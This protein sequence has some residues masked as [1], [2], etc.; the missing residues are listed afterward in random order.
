MSGDARAAV[1]A[2]PGDLFT[3]RSCGT[4]CRSSWAIPLEG[5]E[6]GRI[7]TLF[8]GVDFVDEVEAAP[9]A[10]VKVLRRR[11]DRACVFLEQ[12]EQ[13]RIHALHGAAAKPSVCRRYPYFPRRVGG[14]VRLH[15]SR[16]CPT[17]RASL[18]AAPAGPDLEEAIREAPPAR[19]IPAAPV[20]LAGRGRIPWEAYLEIERSVV[21]LIEDERWRLPEGLVA[22]GLLL[23]RALEADRPPA[24]PDADETLDLVMEGIARRRPLGALYRY[25]VGT[26]VAA[27]EGPSPLRRTALLLRIFAGLGTV[28][29][30]TLEARVP[31][32]TTLRVQ[33]PRRNRDFERPLRRLLAS[34]LRHGF[35]AASGE[36][37]IGFRLLA[38]S[39]GL[40]RW[41]A[42]A[43][44]AAHGRDVV[45]PDDLGAG[46]SAVEYHFLLHRPWRRDALDHRLV[47]GYVRNF[48]FH[49]SF[50]DSMAFA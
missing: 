4:C 6:I 11:P 16:C 39:Y 50:V 5:D 33:W 1:V 27:A 29:L 24:A 42:R 32:R 12:N 38:A 19:D 36:V 3:C 34:H 9:G 15:L 7:A 20:R 49:P 2:P 48:L 37:E 28:R 25:V 10:R 30:P 41:Y 17:V 13:C 22:A 18:G 47:R 46:I 44:A 43:A 8:P 26:A 21:G 45:H 31:V 14:E 23:D 35:L 40:V